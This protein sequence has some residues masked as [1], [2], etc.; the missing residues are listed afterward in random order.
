MYHDDIPKQN[1]ITDKLI[2]LVNKYE[3]NSVATNNCFYI[4]KEDKKTQDVIVA[5]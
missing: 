3:L 1:F 4:S 5:L 2:E